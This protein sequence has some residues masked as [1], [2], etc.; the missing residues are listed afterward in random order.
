[1]EKLLD[2]V[3]AVV[4]LVSPEKVQAIA[5]RIRRTDA[6]K[7]AGAL[8]GAVSTPVAAEV[9][10]QLIDAWRSTS[11][12]AEELASMLLAAG[13]VFT[14]ATNQQSTEL[15]WTGPTTPFVSARRTEQALLQVI[16][17]AENTLFITSFVAYDVSTIVKAL[18][19]ASDR[20]VVISML[21][22]LSQDHGGS[23]TFDAI[24]KMRNLVPSARLYAW[25]DKADP[26]SDGRVHAKV[27]VADGRMCF[28]TSANLT[29]HAMD[30]N[31]EAG[32]LISK[33]HIPPTLDEH[34]RALVSMRIVSPV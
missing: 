7:A 9:V 29:G 16:N 34:L 25:R 20:G 22:E 27:A 32:L 15:V 8:S 33:G 5:S 2:A 23:I 19:A 14:K 6:G 24:G 1:M 21:L 12:S 26:F 18:N 11:V 30:R 28:I 3:A 31:M 10:D 4:C 13:H 17:A